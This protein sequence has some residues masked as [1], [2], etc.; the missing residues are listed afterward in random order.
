MSRVLLIQDNLGG[1]LFV[2]EMLQE[3]GM[4]RRKSL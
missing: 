4:N 3:A 2:K 1:T